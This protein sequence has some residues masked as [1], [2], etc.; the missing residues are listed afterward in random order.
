MLD[1]RMCKN[2]DVRFFLGDSMHKLKVCVYL[3]MKTRVSLTIED[4]ILK[5]AKAL[6]EKQ[7]ISLSK[8]VED[9]LKMV[10]KSVKRPTIF[11]IVDSFGAL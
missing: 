2:A 9:Y 8:L 3:Y 7:D 10:T 1:L 11:D 5:S 6:A 4:N